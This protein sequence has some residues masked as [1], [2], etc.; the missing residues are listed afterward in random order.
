[1]DVAKERAAQFG[2]DTRATRFEPGRAQILQLLC[3]ASVQP[4]NAVSSLPAPLSDLTR[5]LRQQV[6]LVTN[7]ISPVVHLQDLL[8]GIHEQA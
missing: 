4:R 3:A 8:L 2:F 6:P 7:A 1:M 5:E